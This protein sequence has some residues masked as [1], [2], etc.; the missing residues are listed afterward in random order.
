MS[1]S[2]LLSIA[3]GVVL[4]AFVCYTSYPYVDQMAQDLSKE[5]IGKQKEMIDKVVQPEYPVGTFESEVK[6]T[7]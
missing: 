4:A 1:V 5:V 2:D 3:F 6:H 7:Q